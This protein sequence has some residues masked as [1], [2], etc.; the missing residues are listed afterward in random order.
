MAGAMSVGLAVSVAPAASAAEIAPDGT[1]E[2]SVDPWVHY[3]LADVSI[4]TGA[5]CATVP[6]NT[7]QYSAGFLFNGVAIEAGTEYTFSF[8]ASATTDRAIRALVGQNGAPYGTVTDNMPALTSEMQ[9]FE[10]VFTAGATY[11]AVAN[12]E[13]PEGQIAFQPGGNTE[14]YTLCLDNISLSSSDELLPQTSFADGLGEWSFDGGATV[15]ATTVEGGT[16]FDVPG[17]TASPWSLNLHYDGVAIETGQ[18]YK[19]S[20]T[21]SAT[22]GRTV[23]AIVGEAGA[24]F[25][26]VL[27][28]NP[29]LTP[30]LETY[31]YTFTASDTFPADGDAPGQVALQVGGNDAFVLCVTEISLMAVAEPPPPYEPETFSRV[32]VNQVG[33]LPEGP[34]KA[35]LVTEATTALPWSLMQGATTVATGTSTPQ[36]ID[37]T[38]DLNV[39]TIDFSG[40]TTEGE[41]YTLVADGETS[42]P[43]A[44]DAD[45]Y[46]Q[47]RVDALS[48]FY[49]Q[50]SGIEILADVVGTDHEGTSLARPAGH[51][52]VGP[53][54]GDHDV[55]CLPAGAL[56]VDGEDLY[57][58]YTCD[59]TLDVVGGWYD[60]G[61]HGK[62]VVNGGISVAQLMSTYE[63]EAN[64]LSAD[65]GALG[66]G[67]LRVPEGDNGV[68]DV[69]DEARWELEWMLSMQV[70]AGEQYAGMVHHKITDESWTGIPLLPSNDDRARYLHRPST[71]ATLNMAAVAAQGARVF[72]EYDEDFANELLAASEVAYAAALATPDLM[73]PNTNTHP[74]PGGGPYDDSVTLDDEFYWAAAELF[75]TTAGDDYLDDV[76]ANPF[77]L[78]GESDAF[79]ING[80]DW[81]DVAGHVRI[82]LA[83][84][85]SLLPQRE[86][87][88]ASVVA[89]ADAL[90]ALQADQHFGQP[91]AGVDGRF[92]WGSNGKVLNNLVVL[93]AAFDV[94][95]NPAYSHAAAEGMDY[96]LGRNALNISYVT[97]YGEHFAENQ[98]SR[99]YAS[100]ANAALPHP[101]TGTVSGGP[102]SDVPDPVSNPIFGSD[103]GET[104]A[105]QFCYIDDIGAWGVNEL[106]INWN[107]PLAYVASFLAD[108]DDAAVTPAFPDVPLDDRFNLPIQWL[109]ASGIAGG[110]A[111][112]SFRPTTPVSRQAMAAFLY[113]AAGSPEFEAPATS[114]FKDVKV[115]DEF[116]TEIT[117][118]AETGISAGYAGGTFRPTAPVSRQAMAAFLHRAFGAPAFDDPAMSPFTDVPTSSE[119]Y[120]EIAWLAANQISTGDDGGTFRPTSPVSRQAMAAFL[121][122]AATLPVVADDDAVLTPGS[123]VAF[124][125]GSLPV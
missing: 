89:A 102:N 55:T 20:I 81:R 54:Q 74:N 72:A 31:E 80:H 75:L 90:V 28:T 117:W 5:M 111:D 105:P 67:S 42:F 65:E 112:G 62:Y 125:G 99:W 26:T 52:N 38:S 106:T 82:Q 45:L 22:P 66:D 51:I 87:V 2:S 1:F 7:G 119:F 4:E 58:G 61:D 37:P 16:C 27:D 118:L 34:K 123:A 85:P 88:R 70:P 114:P 69:L 8:D 109:K 50:R 86:A 25:T 124:P 59:Y 3:G 63:R 83:T 122:R 120:T 47:L 32:R 78:G 79:Q 6:A 103:E 41:G 84:V 73:A 57:D 11:P 100:Q 92:E 91:Y 15:S 9:H 108:Q 116:Y 19:L 95:H 13:S 44:I 48:F 101:P 110:Y 18:N 77:H 56:V 93:G 33:Y 115:T 64:A 39:H 121:M 30:E 12:A 60:A 43:F 10:Y 49:P 97:G 14:A 46:E 40:V 35:T 98:H 107:A 29:A 17:G 76:L 53:N 104:C 23:R 96:I 36:G 113:R 21:A 24:D 94:T 71:A 68:P